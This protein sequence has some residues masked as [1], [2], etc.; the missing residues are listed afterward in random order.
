MRAI[1]LAVVL[2]VISSW[3]FHFGRQMSQSSVSEFY[4]EQ[5]QLMNRFEAKAL[6]T[7]MATR[8]RRPPSCTP[9]TSHCSASSVFDGVEEA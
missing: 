9:S 3:Y 7:T 1:V 5:L 6:C 2:V 8:V 4:R